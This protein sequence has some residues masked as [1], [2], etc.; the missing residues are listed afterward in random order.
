MF[1]LG[2]DALL[3]RRHADLSP[4]CRSNGLRHVNAGVTGKP[5]TLSTRWA[6]ARPASAPATVIRS[7]SPFRCIFGRRATRWP[8]PAALRHRQPARWRVY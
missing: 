8:L 1:S 2:V 3:A 4:S 7:I 5:T 6:G